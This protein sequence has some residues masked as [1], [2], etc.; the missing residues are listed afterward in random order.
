MSTGAGP[1]IEPGIDA[2]R[3]GLLWRR[4]D[5]IV[6]QALTGVGLTHT[7]GTGAV[8][9]PIFQ[10][11]TYAQPDVGVHLGHEDVHL[12]G[13]VSETAYQG[14]THWLIFLFEV[15]RPVRPDELAWEEFDEGRLEWIDAADVES[16]PIPET[17]R[18][19]M[20]P[21]VRAHR[22][23]FFVVHIDC[24]VEPFVWRLC[25]SHT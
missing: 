8:S 4:L 5:G 3:L 16:L 1:G 21:T 25:E 12:T 2:I 9:V 17:D 11:S 15:T 10:T 6:D 20:W 22:G 13:V 23:G 14:E 19:V 18:R 7:P 24:S